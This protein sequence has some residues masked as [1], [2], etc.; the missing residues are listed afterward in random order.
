[1]KNRKEK[2][3]SGKDAPVILLIFTAAYALCMG[4]RVYYFMKAGRSMIC[5]ADA[6]EQ[7]INALIA[8]GKWM[9]GIAYTLIHE[10][11]LAFGNYSFG[12]GMGADFYTSMQYYAVGDPLNLPAAFLPSTAVYHYFQF[13]ILLRPYLAGL[14]FIALCLYRSKSRKLSVPGIVSGALI[15]AFSGTVLFIGMW[16]PFFVT[17]MITLPLLVRGADRLYLEGRR[18]P[19]VLAVFLA[20]VSNFYFFYMQTI[21]IF[22]YFFL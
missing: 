15:Y 10:H 2:T 19:F 1:M 20:G 8:Y 7:H 11:R 12:I 9:R 5:D 13:L 21:F 16:N 18:V 22:G 17:P 6:I 4:L 14:A 3:R